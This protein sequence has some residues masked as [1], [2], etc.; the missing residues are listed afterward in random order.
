MDKKELLSECYQELFFIENHLNT[1]S[2]AMKNGMEVEDELNRLLDKYNAV[3]QA[4]KE[5]KNN[6]PGR[7]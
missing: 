3:K 5:L 2:V 6:N 1:L 7:L 4:I